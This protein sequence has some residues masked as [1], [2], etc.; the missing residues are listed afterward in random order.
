[1]RLDDLITYKYVSSTVGETYVKTS[2]TVTLKS[3]YILG[4]EERM[5]MF[6]HE[7]TNEQISDY[8]TNKLRQDL[9]RQMKEMVDNG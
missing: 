8:L 1:M 2:A 5:D 3:F 9:L 4:E 6:E 7:L